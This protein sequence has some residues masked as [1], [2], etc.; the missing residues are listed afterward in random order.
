MYIDAWLSA[1]C[2][3]DFKGASMESCTQLINYCQQHKIAYKVTIENNSGA[4]KYMLKAITTNEAAY[5]MIRDYK[6]RGGN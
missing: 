2:E 6:N 1:V 4:L 3:L 5:T